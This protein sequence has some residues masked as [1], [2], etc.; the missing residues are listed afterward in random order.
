[1]DDISKKRLGDAVPGT[2]TL[3]RPAFSTTYNSSSPALV[4]ST[5]AE[6]PVAKVCRDIF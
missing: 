4:I 1:M 3:M 5:G 6:K 2:N